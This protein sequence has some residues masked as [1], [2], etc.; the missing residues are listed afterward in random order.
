MNTSN[1]SLTPS[2]MDVWG[3]AADTTSPD[4]QIRDIALAGALKMIENLQHHIAAL[5][6]AQKS[7][8]SADT[9]TVGKKTLVEYQQAA[10]ALYMVAEDFFYSNGYPKSVLDEV[11]D[12][13]NV[14]LARLREETQ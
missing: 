10:R 11:Q 13:Y 1:P 2:P 12:K 5:E 6:A 3:H 8:A 4:W 14:A 7:N 9:V